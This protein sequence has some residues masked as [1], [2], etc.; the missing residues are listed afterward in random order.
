MSV[1]SVLAVSWAGTMA[2]E[3]TSEVVGDGR[4]PTV[5]ELGCGEPG[6]A[7]SVGYWCLFDGPGRMRWVDELFEH[8]LQWSEISA[9]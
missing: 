5:V 1:T 9:Q 2:R 6:Y 7:N 3:R 8:G 4:L